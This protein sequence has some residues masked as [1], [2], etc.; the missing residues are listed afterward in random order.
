MLS[1]QGG[2]V[3]DSSM[4]MPGDAVYLRIVEDLR[5]ELRVRKEDAERRHARA[6]MRRL[7]AEIDELDADYERIVRAAV[8]V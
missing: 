3:G 8:L 5:R 2:S 6:Q 1:H 4:L 7:Q